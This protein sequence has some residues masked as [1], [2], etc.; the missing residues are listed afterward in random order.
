M[1][2]HKTVKF[3]LYAIAFWGFLSFYFLPDF[4]HPTI[5]LLVLLL[6][7]SWFIV[8]T[9]EP[10][11]GYKKAWVVVTF[12][13]L[14]I[15]CADLILNGR[16]PYLTLAYQLSFLQLCKLYNVKR[17]KDYYQI[18]F[19]AFTMMVVAAIK[20]ASDVFPLMLVPFLVAAVYAFSLITIERE[21]LLVQEGDGIIVRRREKKR[22]VGAIHHD[23]ALISPRRAASGL[24]ALHPMLSLISVSTFALTVFFFL[25]FPR[26]TRLLDY[27]T[28]PIYDKNI[29]NEMVLTGYSNTIDLGSLAKI[30]RDP[31]VIM[32][33]RTSMPIPE[34]RL[35][36]RG[37][38]L[39]LF[40][41]KR[42]YQKVSAQTTEK[43]GDASS[44]QIIVLDEKE[45]ADKEHLVREDIEMVDFDSKTLFYMPP[46]VALT[47]LNQNIY[48]DVN[49]YVFV[50]PTKSFS[51]RYSA[52]S[53]IP[54][55]AKLDYGYLMPVDAETRKNVDFSAYL[56]VPPGSRSRQ[57][58][59]LK[60]LAQ[61]ITQDCADDYERAR[62]IETYLRKNYDYTLDLRTIDSAQPIQHFLFHDK[63]GHCELFATSM[64][65]LLRSVEI[66]ARLVTGF[67]GGNF[68]KQND[69][70]E[71]R[72]MDAHTWVEAYIDGEGWYQFD[73]TPAPPMEIFS[74][75]LYF[76]QLKALYESISVR[77]KNLVIDY[78]SNLRRKI[79]A[80]ISR[81]VGGAYESVA[82]SRL[83]AHFWRKFSANITQA[84]VLAVALFLLSLNIAAAVLLMR[85][86]RRGL[87]LS[88]LLLGSR[89]RHY[90]SYF[91]ERI[92]LAIHGQ[93]VQKKSEA[94]PRE[95]ALSLAAARQ[96]DA[97][98]VEDLMTIYYALRFGSARPSVELM[99]RV[100]M[101]LRQLR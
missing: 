75:R 96:K 47:N 88:A 40:D 57:K 35:Y 72:K 28:Q 34:Q 89:S 67:R 82:N 87:H 7:P 64:V 53:Y 100:E 1:S 66:P 68:Q 37:M 33:V 5:L 94:T 36:L 99:R 49:C 24:R 32:K 21:Q 97:A 12:L 43:F 22:G 69:I 2:S 60:P 17:P 90:L 63:R 92:I 4:S 11:P 29:E 73:P 30:L 59:D 42:W 77:W 9:S 26:S 23:M 85:L 71:I 61:D 95:F 80:G 52:Y 39:D 20:S 31:T 46:L 65:L 98:I 18:L 84:P 76:K 55:K 15:S 16:Q 101:L 70:Y 91:Y 54:D 62:A 13:F 83:L 10:F 3:A 45:F 25:F 48:C 38:T 78:N 27:N 79:F 56:L 81:T 19:L 86:R 74:G 44:G 51:P 50:A 93:V 58:E 6:L 14:L 8:Q 41:G